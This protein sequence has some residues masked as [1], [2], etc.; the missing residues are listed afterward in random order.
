M[1][2]EFFVSGGAIG[3]DSCKMICSEVGF[4]G[5]GGVGFCGTGCFED[6]V[7]LDLLSCF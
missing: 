6:G 2:A 4:W 5:I 1:R 3:F 7:C